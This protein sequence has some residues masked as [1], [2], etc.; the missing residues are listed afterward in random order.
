MLQPVL[1]GTSAERCRLVPAA[2]DVHGD[3]D[4]AVLDSRNNIQKLS[5]ASH[6]KSLLQT[7]LAVGCVHSKP[8][9]LLG[10]PEEI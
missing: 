8:H 3:T 7:F 9:L 4:R 6:L 1:T 2:L 5:G 10:Y